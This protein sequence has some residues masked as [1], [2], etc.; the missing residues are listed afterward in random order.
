MRAGLLDK[1]IELYS[2]ITETSEYGQTT[3]TYAKYCST[4]AKV[5]KN[6]G[7][8]MNQNNEEFFGASFQF[9]VRYYIP[10]KYTD[11]IHFQG[12]IYR[13]TSILKDETSNSIIIETERVNE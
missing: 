13:V 11:Q 9:T 3:V 6:T 4:K 2:R 12:E 5:Y 10:V 1:T 8:R 7:F